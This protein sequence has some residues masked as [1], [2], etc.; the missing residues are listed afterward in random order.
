M[1]K[2]KS[3]PTVNELGIT[4]VACSP[5]SR[6]FITGEPCKFEDLKADDMRTKLPRFQGDNFQKNV[7][8][9]DKLGEIAKEKNVRLFN[10]L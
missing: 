2:R 8:I 4:F 6:G 10:W 9:V 1:F 3:I 7:D 5:L